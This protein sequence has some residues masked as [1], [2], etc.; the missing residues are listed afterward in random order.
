MKKIMRTIA[1]ASLFVCS[2]QISKSSIIV[3][4]KQ[5]VSSDEREVS[6]FSG[7]SSSGSFDVFVTLGDKES[8]RLEGDPERL[9]EIETKV[10]D[11]IL[12][13]RTKDLIKSWNGNK[14]KVNIYITAKALNTLTM[15]GSGDMKVDGTVKADLL[16]TKVSGSGSI[17]LNAD[18]HNYIGVISGSG[19]INAKGNTGNAKITI[20][21][22]GDFKGREF[23]SASADIKVSG[24]GDASIYADQTL[25]AVISGSGHIKY[26]G[27]A[28]VSETKSGSGGVSKF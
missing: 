1:L 3:K 10:E 28:Q 8:L 6:G 23:H 18:S 16:T 4:N 17:S 13:I 14:G 22:S 26:E 24:S 12:K 19:G 21:G 9:S 20:A 27:N 2:S 7:I 25:D 5:V 15:S 11:G